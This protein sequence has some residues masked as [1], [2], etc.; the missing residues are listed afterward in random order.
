MS[1]TDITKYVKDTFGVAWREHPAMEALANA[2]LNTRTPQDFCECIVR[3]YTELAQEHP[4]LHEQLRPVLMGIVRYGL[5]QPSTQ[6]WWP[7]HLAEVMPI[8]TQN[9]TNDL[10]KQEASEMSRYLRDMMKRGGDSDVRV[11]S[12]VYYSTALWNLVGEDLLGSRKPFNAEQVVDAN[13]LHLLH[14]Y[15]PDVRPLSNLAQSNAYG[16]MCG[17]MSKNKSPL[18]G[19]HNVLVPQHNNSQA[20]STA[21]AYCEKPPMGQWQAMTPVFENLP[22][23]PDDRYA[24]GIVSRLHRYAEQDPSCATMLAELSTKHQEMFQAYANIWPAI[25][26]MYDPN[27]QT[28]AAAEHWKNTAHNIAPLSIPE[29]TPEMH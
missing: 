3:K 9:G 2:N 14:R 1:N 20:W 5:A 16:Q 19:M 24:W 23:V 29:D 4:E 18:L 10:S 15:E 17:W 28:R 8:L 21:L 11:T 7:G 27:E 25:S 26:A 12:M 22:L 13:K 6:H